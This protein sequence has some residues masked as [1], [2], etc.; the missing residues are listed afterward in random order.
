MHKRTRYKNFL[1][2]IAVPL[3]LIIYAHTAQ[4][5]RMTSPSYIIKTDVLSGGGAH[6]DST[7]YILESTFGQS[8]PLEISEFAMSSN[9]HNYPGFW[10]PVTN[11]YTAVLLN[12]FSAYEAGGNVVVAW[13]TASEIGTV[14]FYLQRLNE[15]TGKYSR[16]NKKFLPG[17]LFSPQGGVYRLVD[18]NAQAEGTYTYQLVEVEAKGKKRTYGPF[19]VTVGGE[20]I[21][22]SLGTTALTD[23]RVPISG[24]SKTAHTISSGRNLR[25][26]SNELAVNT[27]ETS[28][29]V[30]SDKVKIAVNRSGLYYVSASEIA[31]MMGQSIDI[32]KYGIQ[33]RSLI[34]G[35]VSRSAL[36]VFA[37]EFGRTDCSGDC[38]GDIDP[39]GDVDGK[40]LSMFAAEFSAI[41]C[42]ECTDSLGHSVAWLAAEDNAGIYFY[43][44][45]VDSIYT[46]KNIYYLTK[47]I[48][49]QGLTMDVVEGQGPSPSGG[50]K[51]FTDTIHTEEDHY[52]ATALFDNPQADFWL[53]DYIIAGDAS[54]TF[55]VASNGAAGENTAT[56]KVHLQGLTDTESIQ[57]HHVEVS[58]NGTFIGDGV[59]N[60]AL[61]HEL[62]IEFNQSLLNNGDNTIE[63]TGLLDPGVEYSI[64]YVDSFDLTYR[65]YYQ[66]VDNRLL[67]RGDGNDVVTISGFDSNNILVFDLGNPEKPKLVKAVT[68]DGSGGNYRISFLP[69][70]PDKPYLALTID[71]VR[72]PDSIIPDIPSNLKN[73]LNQADY[74]VITPSFLKTA[75]ETLAGY[76]QSQGLETMVVDIEDI[77]DEFNHGIS[78]PEAIKSFLSY[79]YLDWANPP[80]YVVLAGK[81]TYDYKDNLGYGDNLVPPLMAPTPNGL[82]ASD[83][84]FVDVEGDDGVPE[85]A[86]G[87]LP[88]ITA[89]EFNVFIDKIEAYESSDGNWKNRILMLA[90]NPD[91]AGNF[92]DDSDGLVGLLPSNEYETNKIYLSEHPLEEARLMV[93][94]GINNGALL[95]NYIGHAGLDRLT[96]E[97]ILLS[98]DVDSLVNGGRLPV[99]TAMTCVAGRFSIPGYDSLAE[100]LVLHEGG[101]AIAIW[102]PTGLSINELAVIMD[103]AF[104]CSAFEDEEKIL[105]KNVLRTLEDYAWAGR[106]RFMLDIYNLLGDPALIMW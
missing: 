42:P 66:A 23:W 104:F 27:S 18:P 41:E 12:S 58:L 14:G 36:G 81:G 25:T 49:G 97:G 54:K 29:L 88:V 95:M 51:T 83:N 26:A 46:K 100:L 99:V 106:P 78:S 87:R 20:D 60:G 57:D 8:S 22:R 3:A 5:T 71:A 76:H 98:S 72:T 40:D 13:E 74:I 1:F 24:Y 86:I 102:A 91:D 48:E 90:D 62:D 53:W 73:K 30:S 63:V 96:Q 37:A 65:R 52:A 61:P 101:G 16:V 77:Y 80:G 9:Y 6:M 35:D 69:S 10:T 105:G 43:G 28:E 93:L 64:F 34:I 68:K 31:G 33:K 11:G 39:D 59:W 38:Q 75:A 15:K 21:F 44:E 67:A 70:D 82:F 92:S 32:I 84:R 17:L 55:H 45:S 94:N 89:E 47:G 50:N 2:L 4:G 79:A 7:N 103:K 56:L 19:T 85:M